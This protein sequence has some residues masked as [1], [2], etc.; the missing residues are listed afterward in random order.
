MLHTVKDDIGLCKEFEITPH[1]LLFV[2]TLVSDPRMDK[3][4]RKISATKLSLEF[5]DVTG[6]VSPDEMADLISRDIVIDYND[7]GKSSYDY[8]EINPKWASKFELQVY[9]MASQLQDAYPVRFKGSDGKLYLGVTAS[10]DEIAM[11]YYRAIDMS[12]EEHV[13]V[14]DDL[15]WGVKNNGIVMGL[16]KFVITKYWKVLREARGKHKANVSD[17]KIV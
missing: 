14:L 8:Y 10:A 11:D 5:K 12:S 1:Q 13:R 16:K 4:E 2:K 17:V 3:A 15:A 9:P 6:G 7:Y